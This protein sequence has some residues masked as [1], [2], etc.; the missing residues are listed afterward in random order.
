MLEERAIQAAI[1]VN[2]VTANFVECLEFIRPLL[3]QKKFNPFS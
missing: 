1:A 3:S 2:D